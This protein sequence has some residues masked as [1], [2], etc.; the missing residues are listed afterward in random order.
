MN[1]RGF[2]SASAVTVAGASVATSA[3]AE[4]QAYWDKTHSGRPAPNA[5]RPLEV[6]EYRPV[7]TPSGVSLPFEI[8]DGV[9]VYHLVAEEVWN[10]FAPGLKALCW[11]YNGR[12]HGP[13]IEGVEGERIR[14]YVTNRLPAPTSVH[15]H[16]VYLPS[17]MDGVG[18][19]QDICA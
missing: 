8:V 5:R 11:G 9:K 1:R 7:I 19:R 15:W 13:T 10:E 12:V 2:L 18:G 17:G 16:G 6:G 3:V 4:N 14:V